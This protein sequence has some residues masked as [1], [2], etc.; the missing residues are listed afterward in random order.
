MWSGRW[1]R[2]ILTRS[3]E[4]MVTER[5]LV[6][7]TRAERSSATFPRYDYAMAFVARSRH[8]ASIF[9]RRD[10]EHFARSS[11]SFFFLLYPPFFTPVYDHIEIVIAWNTKYA[12][13]RLINVILLPYI[14]SIFDDHYVIRYSVIIA[15][16]YY[17]RERYLYCRDIWL[18]IPIYW[19]NIRLN[20][21]N[22]CL[23][24]AK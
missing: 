21:L 24:M 7:S 11:L 12:R 4:H 6:K 2:R 22:L 13:I 17:N 20:K 18:N 3:K 14:Y 5:D 16:I 19:R 10:S 1:E 15:T 23:D 8:V 9:F